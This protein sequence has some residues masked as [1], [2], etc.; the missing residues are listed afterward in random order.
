MYKCNK[1]HLFLY[2]N[3][4]SDGQLIVLNGFKYFKWLPHFQQASNMLRWNHLF[5]LS[6][7]SFHETEFNLSLFT[8]WSK[9]QSE[10][11]YG[12]CIPLTEVNETKS[13][14]IQITKPSWLVYQ[15]PH[16]SKLL[17]LWKANTL[18]IC[19]ADGL[20]D[21]NAQSRVRCMSFDILQL[22]AL[23]AIYC[24]FSSCDFSKS[25]LGEKS[26]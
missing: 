2:F 5:S 16:L 22:L 10:F 19:M 7:L 20:D 14:Q 9:N 13:S 3:K 12:D 11:N 8:S 21:Y 18:K 4:Q 26:G 15:T 6:S 24:Q 1:L 23:S 17:F 25:P